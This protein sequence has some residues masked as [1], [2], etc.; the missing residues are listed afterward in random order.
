VIN[1][2]AAGGSAVIVAG[3]PTPERIDAVCA[4]EKVSAR[5]L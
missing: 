5:N 2:L 1:P 4:A 3:T